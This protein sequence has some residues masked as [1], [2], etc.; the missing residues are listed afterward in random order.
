M[1]RSGR[2]EV[3]RWWAGVCGWGGTEGV[4]Y[5]D[6]DPTNTYLTTN[7]GNPQSAIWDE[8]GQTGDLTVVKFDDSISL[9][10]IQVLED[11]TFLEGDGTSYYGYVNWAGSLAVNTV[12][13]DLI[14]YSD[15][16]T[17]ITRFTATNSSGSGDLSVFVASPVVVPAG[18]LILLET[19]IDPVP[20]TVTYQP[21]VE[22]L[23]S[24]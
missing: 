6:G 18:G 4:Y 20:S 21:T 1:S 7:V 2:S 5:M 8:A 14:F 24:A 13:L 9:T 19:T 11:V 10:F 16:V 23:W 12:D 22:L 3:G 15:L 17:E